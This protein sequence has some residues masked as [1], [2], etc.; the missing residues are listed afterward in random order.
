MIIMLLTAFEEMLLTNLLKPFD[1]ERFF[2][3]FN[4]AKEHIDFK[5]RKNE[6]E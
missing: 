1:K 6:T 5:N 4:R 3:S 2:K